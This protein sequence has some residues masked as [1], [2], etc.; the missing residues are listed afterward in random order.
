[1]QGFVQVGSG[2]WGFAI[3]GKPFTPVGCNYYPNDV[4]WAPQMWKEFDPEVF[5]RDFDLM[6]D[7]GLNTVRLFIPAKSVQPELGQI[8]TTELD[9][10]E[11]VV[12]LADE[13]GMRLILDGLDGWEGNPPYWFEE[14]DEFGRVFDPYSLDGALRALEAYWTAMSRRFAN[15]QAI[16]AWSLKNEPMIVWRSSSMKR[17]WNRWLERRY[18]ADDAIGRAWGRRPVGECLGSYSIP[19]D[20]GVEGDGRLYDYQLFREQVAREWCAV[21]VQAI[22]DHD[23]K[24]LVTVGHIQ[25]SFPLKRPAAS[26]DRGVPSWYSGFN[27]KVLADL[28][29]Y[30]SIHFYPLL[31]DPLSSQEAY[32]RNIKYLRAVVDYAYDNSP[33]VLEEFGWYGGGKAQDKPYRTQE[34]QNKWNTGVVEHTKDLCCGWLNWGLK[35]TPAATDISIYSGLCDVDGQPKLW[36]KTLGALVKELQGERLARTGEK[37][38]AEFSMRRALTT[39]DA[40]SLLAEYVLDL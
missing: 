37:A 29:D 32:E 13:R 26:S 21:Q 28:L 10:I 30:S 6:A 39:G 12:D 36:G 14:S 22:R 7:L 15:R 8:V 40:E 27:P 33:V 19:P 38:Y 18:G 11:E 31:G 25:W 23:S 1:M 24:H 34:E 5:R 35:D 2:G 16:M 20:K 9:K 4:G 3:D 17:K